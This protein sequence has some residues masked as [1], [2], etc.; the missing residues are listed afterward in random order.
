MDCIFPE[1]EI[2]A[3]SD[4]ARHWLTVVYTFS[5]AVEAM[6]APRHTISSSKKNQALCAPVCMFL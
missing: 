6:F 2:D 3:G 5:E 4:D 1:R